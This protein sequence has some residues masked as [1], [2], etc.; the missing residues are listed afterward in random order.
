MKNHINGIKFTTA[1]KTKN[2]ANF[3]SPFIPKPSHSVRKCEKPRVPVCSAF[4]TTN[5]DP[6]AAFYMRLINL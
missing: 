4:R 5:T 6:G 3:C 2:M 1:F